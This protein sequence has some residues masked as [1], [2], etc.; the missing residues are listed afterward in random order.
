MLGYAHGFDALGGCGAEDVIGMFDLGLVQKQM[1]GLKAVTVSIAQSLLRGG[2][3][4]IDW[5][6][7]HSV[8]TE[9]IPNP[10]GAPFP[11][12]TALP[13]GAQRD[14][15]YG[16]LKWHQDALSKVSSTPNAPYAPGADLKNWVSRAFVEANAV[17][18][19]AAYLDQA[20][21][22]MWAEIA[23]QL[24]ALPAALYDKASGALDEVAWYAKLTTWAIILAGTG[25]AGAVGFGLYRRVSGR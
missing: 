6:R 2:Q 18:E 8:H 14:E 7:S 12:P 23:A 3:A 10:G 17:E 19:G 1:N 24:A 4:A 21:S 5:A 9:F 16:H 22:Q 15:V 13:G 11:V 25:V 20:W